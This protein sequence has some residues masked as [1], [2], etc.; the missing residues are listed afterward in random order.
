[1]CERYKYILIPN[2]SLVFF[3]G[4]IERFVSLASSCRNLG[5]RSG[6]LEVSSCKERRGVSSSSYDF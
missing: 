4:P 3:P 6:R 1:M 2:L 5:V